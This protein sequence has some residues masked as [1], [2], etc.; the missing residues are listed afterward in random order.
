MAP[1]AGDL[2]RQHARFPEDATSLYGPC[3]VEWLLLSLL[4][5]N[6]TQDCKGEGLSQA[7]ETLNL[8]PSAEG[9]RTLASA[10]YKPPWVSSLLVG[11]SYCLSVCLGS[12][13]SPTH[14]P[15]TNWKETV[16][17]VLPCM[18]LASGKPPQSLYHFTNA[19]GFPLKS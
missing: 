9:F 5:N 19:S 18:P 8:F 2:V 1:S 10:N 17:R 4:G 6:N 12:L 13:S 7:N 14:C 16:Q 3:T 11:F 15:L